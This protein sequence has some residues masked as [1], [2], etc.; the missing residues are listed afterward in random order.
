MCLFA[1][2][3]EVPGLYR[4]AAGVASDSPPVLLGADV[5]LLLRAKL[6]GG[7]SIR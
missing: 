2:G 1:G 3:G 6:E 7:V 5:G 4:S